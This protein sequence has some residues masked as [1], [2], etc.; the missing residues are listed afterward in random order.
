MAMTLKTC[1]H[2]RCEF[3]VPETEVWAYKRKMRMPGDRR[4]NLHWFCRWNC[5]AQAQREADEYFERLR[6]ERMEQARRRMRRYSA[7]QYAKQ[8]EQR[9]T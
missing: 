3:V 9:T 4:A 6:C 5:L 8:K 2:C 1:E 7:A